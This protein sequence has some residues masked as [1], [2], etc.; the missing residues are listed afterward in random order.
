L[1]IV[2]LKKHDEIKSEMYIMNSVVDKKQKI[3]RDKFDSS[4]SDEF[5]PCYRG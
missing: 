1:N 3:P 2:A 5:L 4:E